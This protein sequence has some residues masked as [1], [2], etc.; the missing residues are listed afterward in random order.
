MKKGIFFISPEQEKNLILAPGDL[1]QTNKNKIKNNENQLIN[2]RKNNI[3]STSKAKHIQYISSS[4][5]QLISIGTG[6]IPFLEHDD[7]NRALMGSNMQRQALPLASKEM[8]LI[9]TG[10][11]IQIA[12]ESQSTILAKK[13][14]IIKYV[15]N[16]KIII[17]E[18]IKFLSSNKNKSILNK[19]KNIFKSKEKINTKEKH[20]FLEKPRKSNQNSYLKQ[21]PIIN[22]W[23][24]VKKGQIIA[25]GTG[26]LRGKLSLG[27][28][29]LIGYLSWE[30]Y[31]FEDA[32]VINERLV[33]EDI[34]TS[35]HI[36]KYKS[37]IINNEKG[38]VRISKLIL[39]KPLLELKIK[40]K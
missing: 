39:K 32:I 21:H 8:P 38:E 26:T 23:E 2:I 3:F 25:E 11:E 36:K 16:K 6:L 14:G 15:S 4:T 34:F 17:N 13:S 5:N 35:V 31:N 22:K 9:E 28:N 30:G 37:F 12:K 33:Q 19:H 20:Y 29:I 27:K 10:I 7:A 1:F 40:G 24:W 18:R